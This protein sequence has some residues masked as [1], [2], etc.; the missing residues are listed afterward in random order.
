MNNTALGK[1]G[2]EIAAKF[3]KTKGFKIIESNFRIRGGEID[4]VAVDNKTLVY[5]EV[6]TRT[7]EEFGKPEESV[8]Q[9]KIKFLERAAKFYKNSRQ[10]LPDLE[11]I[12]VIAIDFS[13]PSQALVKH[14]KKCRILTVDL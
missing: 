6:K 2:E 10:N 11:R 3:L 9:R 4:I 8:T 12:D 14:I 1:K 13:N 5:V 7:T